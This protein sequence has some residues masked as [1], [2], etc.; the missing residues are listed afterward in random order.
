[1]EISADRRTVH[2]CLEQRFSLPSYQREYKWEPKHFQEL[3]LDIQEAFFE[4]YDDKDGRS[5]VAKYDPYFLGTIITTPASDGMRTIVDGQQRITTLALVI[6]YFARMAKKNPG[7]G[8]SDIG[9]LLRRN[10]FGQNEFNISFDPPRKAL[11]E[12][13]IDHDEDSEKSLD[14]AVESIPELDSGSKRIFE[15]FCHIEN[16]IGR[17]DRKIIPYFVDYLSQRIE[18]FEIN[19]PKEQDGHKVF[20]T[21]ND[22]GLKL[23][24]IDLLKGYLLSNIPDNNQNGIAHQKWKDSLAKLTNLGS[25]ED[26]TFFKTWLRAQYAKSSRGKQKGALPGDFEIISDAYHRWV[27]DNRQDLGLI[28]SDNYFKFLTEDLPFFVDLYVKIKNGEQ[29][30]SD[31]LPYVYFNGHRDLTLQAMLV[32]ACATTSDS[33]TAQNKKIAIVSY[34]LDCFATHRLANNQDNTYNNLRDP[35]FELTRVVR[36]KTAD[37]VAKVF[38]EELFRVMDERPIPISRMLYYRHPNGDLLH[39]LGRVADYLEKELQATNRVG[40][41]GYVQR[42]KGNKTFDIEH[43]LSTGSAQ[44]FAHLGQDNDFSS[45]S[46]FGLERNRLGALILLARSRNRS[47]QDKQYLEK[48]PVYATEAILAQTLTDSFYQN[49][50]LVISKISDL[51]LPLKSLPLFNKGT[52]KARGDFYDQVSG[53]IWNPDYL[54]EMAEGNF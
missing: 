26:S 23:S 44:V 52:I 27:V 40:F 41:D 17:L 14:E 49:N 8:I 48:L 45:E 20:V 31:D 53:Q 9:S 12:L 32:L 39:I 33:P 2:Q 21:M 25:D 16:A 35:L 51:K 28:T 11:F 47:L 50:P 13:L 42:G 6:A 37:D 34:F 5:A 24:P 18:L 43:I 30:Y 38:Y 3:L 7:L 36:K 15:L 22:R 19:V 54:L 1:M 4:N 10:V 29:H 46:E